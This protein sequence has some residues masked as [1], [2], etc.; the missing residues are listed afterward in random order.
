MNNG[1]ERKFNFCHILQENPLQETSKDPTYSSTISLIIS[2]KAFFTT[3]LTLTNL[4]NSEEA[5]PAAHKKS[6]IQDQC[7]DN[8]GTRKYF[9]KG[10]KTPDK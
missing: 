9:E 7:S 10:G 4:L 1:Q 8:H 5:M 2:I 3:A 6:Q